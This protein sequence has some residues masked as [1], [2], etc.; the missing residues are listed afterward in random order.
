MNTYDPDTRIPSSR[1]ATIFGVSAG[2]ALLAGLFSNWL[3]DLPATARWSLSL[4]PLFIVFAWLTLV[5]IRLPISL[6]KHGVLSVLLLLG[7][8]AMSDRIEELSQPGRTFA[9]VV[10]VLSLGILAFRVGV[11]SDAKVRTILALM[12]GAWLLL[13]VFS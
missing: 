9:A 5:N 3:E 1:L 10:L 13:Q 8:F 6:V 12:G 11:L 2:S 7:L 4:S